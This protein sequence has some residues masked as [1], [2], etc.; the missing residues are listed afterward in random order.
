V[1]ESLTRPPDPPAPPAR[2]PPEALAGEDPSFVARLIGP[3]ELPA[4]LEAFTSTPSIASCL[5]HH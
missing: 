1:A 5:T 3:R 4:V 2:R